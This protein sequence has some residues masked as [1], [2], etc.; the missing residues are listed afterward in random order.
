MTAPDLSNV[1][2]MPQPDVRGVLAL[3]NLPTGL[4]LLEDAT[5]FADRECAVNRHRRNGFE[6]PA[7]DTERLLLEHLG[8]MLPEELTTVV[9]FR[10]KS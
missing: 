5:A 3:N 9:K 10:T 4:Q 2:Q 7:T 1:E 6:R 8:Y